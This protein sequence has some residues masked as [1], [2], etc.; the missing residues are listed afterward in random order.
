MSCASEHVSG[1]VEG[2]HGPHRCRLCTGRSGRLS[3]SRRPGPT[4]R[5]RCARTAVVD[6]VCWTAEG[7]VISRHRSS[8]TSGKGTMWFS[9]GV[10]SERRGQVWD[11][12]AASAL[13]VHCFASLGF[14]T[15]GHWVKLF[16]RVRTAPFCKYFQQ[17]SEVS[18]VRCRA[19]LSWIHPASRLPLAQFSKECD[20]ILELTNL[21]S[22]LEQYWMENRLYPNPQQTDTE[23]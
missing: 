7:N 5:H 6:P 17:A 19:E 11:R 16:Q 12:A 14:D 21:R 18:G 3:E 2:W 22:L 1:M 4:Y 13:V 8:V 9:S 23:I 20:H 10:W 15:S